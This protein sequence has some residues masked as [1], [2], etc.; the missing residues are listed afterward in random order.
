MLAYIDTLLLYTNLY[1]LVTTILLDSTEFY[2]SP[3]RPER[4]IAGLLILVKLWLC[5]TVLCMIK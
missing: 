3:S 1:Y 4:I 2:L 5:A